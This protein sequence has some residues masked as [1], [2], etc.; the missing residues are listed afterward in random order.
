LQIVLGAVAVGEYKLADLVAGQHLPTLADV[1]LVVGTADD[2]TVTVSAR[3]A[4]AKVVRGDVS[5][6][7]GFAHIID[8]LLAPAVSSSAHRQ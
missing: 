8:T 3:G 6:S 5:V 2:G 4:T 1:P 7:S